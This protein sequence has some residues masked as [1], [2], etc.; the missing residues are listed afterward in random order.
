MSTEEKDSG[1]SVIIKKVTSLL[2]IN[3]LKKG[4]DVYDYLIQQ[5]TFM[6]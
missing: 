2:G 4:V 5:N 6:K 3:L 1:P